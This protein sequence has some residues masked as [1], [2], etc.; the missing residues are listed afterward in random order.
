MLTNGVVHKAQRNQ[1][2]CCSDSNSFS[3]VRK[4]NQIN[5]KPQSSSVSNNPCSVHKLFKPQML[6]EKKM[7]KAGLNGTWKEVEVGMI[8]V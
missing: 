4:N 1:G 5:H 8:R 6:N 7:R 3:S 2:K